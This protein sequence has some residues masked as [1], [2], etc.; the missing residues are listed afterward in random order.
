[1]DA[2]DS[3]KAL[4]KAGNMTGSIKQDAVG[5]ATTI[6]TLVQNVKDGA[7]LMANT[8]SFTVDADVAKIRVPYAMY[9]ANT[10]D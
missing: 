4:I 5:M 2:T 1:M 9:D 3:A 8:G 6:M 7:E 10:Q